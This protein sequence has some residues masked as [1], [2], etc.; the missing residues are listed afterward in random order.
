M[1]LVWFGHSAFRVEVADAVILIDPFLSGNPSFEGSYEDATAG[2]THVV[3]THGHDDHVGDSARIIKDHNPQLIASFE[4]C[5]WLAEQGAENLNPGNTGGTVPCGPSIGRVVS[6][7]ILGRATRTR[8]PS[9]L[10]SWVPRRR[11]SGRRAYG[12]S[13]VASSTP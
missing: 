2:C 12:K 11:C 6:A 10:A 8:S 3:L 13:F 4:I 5:M 9:W 7:M 1:K